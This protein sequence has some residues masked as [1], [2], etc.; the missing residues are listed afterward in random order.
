MITHNFCWCNHGGD[1]DWGKCIDVL[2]RTNGTARAPTNFTSI[3]MVGTKDEVSALMCCGESMEWPECEGL[4]RKTAEV[5]QVGIGKGVQT[6]WCRQDMSLEKCQIL[7]PEREHICTPGDIYAIGSTCSPCHY[8][9][10]TC[11][12]SYD[13]RWIWSCHVAMKKGGQQQ[14]RFWSHYKQNVSLQR[15][16]VSS[17]QENVKDGMILKSP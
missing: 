4:T 14:S 11:S 12:L 16:V 6:V 2:W 13:C 15:K 9:W 10:W 3:T 17:G 8:T 5:A 7:L 1:Q